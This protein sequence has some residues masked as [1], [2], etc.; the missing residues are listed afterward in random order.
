MKF[1]WRSHT[2][3]AIVYCLQLTFQVLVSRELSLKCF[4]I[5]HANKVHLEVLTLT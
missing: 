5:A 1:I 3:K 4:L 2:R